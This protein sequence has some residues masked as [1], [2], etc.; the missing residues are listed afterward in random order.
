MKAWF[1]SVVRRRA[2]GG[3]QGEREGMSASVLGNGEIGGET[4]AE[5]FVSYNAKRWNVK[6]IVFIVNFVL[7]K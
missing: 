4:W 6:E 2:G 1:S 5:R 3:D 7:I